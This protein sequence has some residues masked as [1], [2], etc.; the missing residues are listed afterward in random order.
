MCI[1]SLWDTL[2]VSAPADAADLRDRVRDLT[3]QFSRCL[4]GVVSPQVSLHRRVTF[5]DW[6]SPTLLLGREAEQSKAENDSP[7]SSA[8]R[9]LAQR[10]R[11]VSR[12]LPRG[13][14]N[15]EPEEIKPSVKS[16]EVDISSLRNPH[17]SKCRHWSHLVYLTRLKHT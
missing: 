7:Q 13:V 6:I 10:S 5:P 15:K 3:G 9:S 16:H 11:K 17:P 8:K 2:V 12:R 4:V 1:V 14:S